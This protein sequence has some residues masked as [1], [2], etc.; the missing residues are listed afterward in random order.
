MLAVKS[1]VG[2]FP[3]PYKLPDDLPHKPLRVETNLRFAQ[4]P[5][6]DNIFG[7]LFSEG[8]PVLIADSIKDPRVYQNGPEDFLKCGSYMFAPIKQQETTVGLIGL[9]K[10]LLLINAM[11][12]HTESLVLYFL[13]S[14]SSMK[15]KTKSTLP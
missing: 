6:K 12:K 8:E 9:A 11:Q 2:K 7:D 14:S 15:R 3:P 5:L 1:L 4:F 13:S 10:P